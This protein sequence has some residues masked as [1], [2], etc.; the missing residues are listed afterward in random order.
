M[1]VSMKEMHKAQQQ[2][3]FEQVEIDKTVKTLRALAMKQTFYQY[4]A[5]EEKLQ[6]WWRQGSSTARRR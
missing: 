3:R 5:Q 4:F 2:A 1:Y 6:K